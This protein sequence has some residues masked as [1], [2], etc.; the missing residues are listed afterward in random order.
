MR[1]T[2]ISIRNFRMLAAVDLSLESDITLVVGKNNTGKTSLFEAIKIFLSDETNISFE[3]FSQN[4]YPTFRDSYAIY[5]RYVAENNDEEK[6]KILKELQGKIPKIEM[7]LRFA[8]DSKKD[9]L[10][11]LSEFITDLDMLRTDAC[12]CVSYHPINTLGLFKDFSSRQDKSVGLIKFLQ[13]KITQYYRV[14]CFAVD[15]P[16]GNRRELEGAFKNKI[17]K[18]VSFEEIHALRILDDKKGDRNNTLALG[19]AKYYKYRNKGGEDITSLESKLQSMSEELKL[20]Y[21]DILGGILSELKT[22]GAHTPIVIPEIVIDSVFDSEAVIKNNIKY[23]YKQDEIDLPES[24]NGLGYS[25]LIYMILE[26]ASFLEKQKNSS[27]KRV[28]QF[29]VVTIEEPE[30]H[31]HPQMQQVFIKQIVELLRKALVDGIVVQL[32]ITSHSSHI[33]SEAGIDVKR[34]FNRLRYFKRKN[35]VVFLKDFNDLY[36][37][38]Q[39][40]TYRFLK[41]YL[42]IHKSDLFFADK[43][44]IVE[45]VTERLLLPQMI[46]KVA[47]ALQ[48]EYVTILEAGGAYTHKFEQILNFVEIKTLVITDLDSIDASKKAC[49]V[50]LKILEQKTS[51]HTLSKWLPKKSLIHE[52]LGSTETDKIYKG[53]VR[54][55]FQINEST[56]PYYSRSFEE[57]FIQVNSS[58]L[59][60]KKKVLKSGKEVEKSVKNEFSRFRVISEESFETLDSFDLAP[61]T[62]KAKTRFAFDVMSF[63]EQEFGKWKV[64]LYIKEG[65]EWLAI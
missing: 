42:N 19:F 31:M 62:S 54:V 46:A 43:V 22:F 27:E 50:D 9:S 41:Q 59:R 13:T 4:C 39:K 11:E 33:I 18:V 65:L 51:N 49:R 44:I 2:H 3:D 6:N 34:G 21:K 8:Y 17:T 26:F 40:K 61:K 53:I 63:N 60:S 7:Y 14:K 1:L 10:V 45:G 29:L 35:D 47:T 15:W 56:P 23:Y 5:E 55:A 32:I 38:D 52:I 57:S 30:A 20:K 25:N 36:V 58:L 64:P 28:S 24:Y 16:T 37:D 12:L 48:N